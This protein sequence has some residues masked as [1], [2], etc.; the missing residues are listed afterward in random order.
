[1]LAKVFIPSILIAASL[2]NVIAVPTA[3]PEA[4]VERDDRTAASAT[5]AT[6]PAEETDPSIVLTGSQ[7]ITTAAPSL[8]TDTVNSATLA[9]VDLVTLPG[10]GLWFPGGYFDS[11]D[12]FYAATAA[13][14]TSSVASA[15]DVPSSGLASSASIDSVATITGTPI[16]TASLTSPTTP[17]DKRDGNVI[18]ALFGG[19]ISSIASEVLPLL[20]SADAAGISSITHKLLAAT[21]STSASSDPTGS[22]AT[23]TSPAPSATHSN[24][25]SAH[26]MGLSQGSIAGA[27]AVVCSIF[28]G[29]VI[30]L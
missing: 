23:T 18:T 2:N 19:L 21:T 16:G 17:P 3:K 25:A 7:V 1:M 26:H 30:G 9:P 5:D 29:G 27:V 28:F 10:G 8:A 22:A 20:P 14:L 12:P 24:A 15:T 6:I 11:V 13:E 4:L